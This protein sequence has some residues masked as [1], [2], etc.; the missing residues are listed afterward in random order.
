[1]HCNQV[2]NQTLRFGEG[3]GSMIGG[4]GMSGCAQYGFAYVDYTGGKLK[5]Y[6]FEERNASMDNYNEAILWL[7]V[8]LQ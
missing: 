5:V 4:H 1:M 2:Q 7:E 8:N 6:H 3:A